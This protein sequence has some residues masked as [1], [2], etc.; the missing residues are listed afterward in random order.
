MECFVL[1]RYFGI[2][3]GP[4]GCFGPF[5][6]LSDAQIVYAVEGFGFEAHGSGVFR[7]EVSEFVA[8]LSVVIDGGVVDGSLRFGL[9]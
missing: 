2:V 8:S 5:S 1:Q 4:V 3:L 7:K 6:Q 9:F